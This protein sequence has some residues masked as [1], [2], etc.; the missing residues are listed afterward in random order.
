MTL[1]SSSGRFIGVGAGK[2]YAHVREGGVPTLVFL[3]YWGGSHRTWRLVVEQLPPE[4]GYSAHD[5]RGWGESQGAPGPFDLGQLA[6]DTQTVID[7]LGL[8][9]FVLVGHSM[10]GKIAQLLAARRPTGLRGLVLVAPAPPA[11]VGVTPEQQENLA[12]AYDDASTVGAALDSALTHHP[13]PSDLRRQVIEDSL[14]G[15]PEARAAWPR[16]GL[17]ADISA[18]VEAIDVPVIVLAG[19]HDQVDPPEVL[20]DHLVPHIPRAELVELSDTGHLSPLEVPGQVAAHL[21]EFT[22]YLTH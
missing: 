16:F 3:H 18:Q 10:G 1:L 22:T 14:R 8:A 11:P 6:D 5:H 7:T 19:K 20:A 13:L 17:V 4:L 9:E 2:L 12:H 21:T 15:H